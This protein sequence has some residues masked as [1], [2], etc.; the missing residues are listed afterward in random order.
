MIRKV[1][2]GD[3]IRFPMETR[4]PRPLAP[5]PPAPATASDRQR[6]LA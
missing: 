4:P 6:P 1:N 5:E 3:D 2:I